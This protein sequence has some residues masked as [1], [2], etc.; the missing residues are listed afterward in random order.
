MCK[1][2]SSLTGCV[3]FVFFITSILNLK[4][5]CSDAQCEFKNGVHQ[6]EQTGVNIDICLMT[7]NNITMTITG[8]CINYCYK[9]GD[10]YRMGD[11]YETFPGYFVSISLIVLITLISTTLIVI[12]C[13]NQEDHVKNYL[14]RVGYENRDFVYPRY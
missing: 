7:V 13:Q 5:G 14:D 10:E 2:V 11:C 1:I 6:I 8:K 12:C 9:Y 3:W 4:Y